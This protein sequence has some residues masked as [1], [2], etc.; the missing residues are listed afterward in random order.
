ML[1]ET[2]VAEVAEVALVELLAN[3][4]VPRIVELNVFWPEIVCAEEISTR[5][6]VSPLAIEDIAPLASVLTV[7]N[8]KAV[9]GGR[10]TN[11]VVCTVP[12]PKWTPLL[13]CSVELN[14]AFA[15]N[16]A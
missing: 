8:G 1:V 4:H 16:C 6:E 11:A 12:S 15:M 3:E 13:A 5:A 10:A 9:D 14:V 7:A 2:L